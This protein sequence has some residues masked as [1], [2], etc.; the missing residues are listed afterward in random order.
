MTQEDEEV[1]FGSDP[2]ERNPPFPVPHRTRDRSGNLLTD[3][4]VPPNPLD[5]SKDPLI[6]KL[7]TMRETLEYCPQLWKELAT[8]NPDQTALIDDHMCDEK[9]DVSFQQM[10]EIVRTSAMI[11]QKMGVKKGVNVAV[12]GENSARWLMIDHGIQ[13]AGG[14]SA[15]RGADAPM[16]E[17]R[18]IYEHSDSAGI[19]SCKDPS[20]WKNFTRMLK[21]KACWDLDL[22]ILPMDK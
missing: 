13:L 22:P 5:H 7:H 14:A 19:P 11:F 8:I 15:V 4:K 10:E 12:L 21:P 6:N 20:F 9:I 3:K 2:T 17:L 16:D 1:L 18:Y